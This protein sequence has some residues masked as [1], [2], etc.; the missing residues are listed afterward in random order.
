[1]WG[2]SCHSKGHN[3]EQLKVESNKPF[4]NSEKKYN[5]QEKQYTSN[6]KTFIWHLRLFIW[7]FSSHLRIFQSYG[8]VTMTGEGLLI[9]TYARHLWPLNSEG[10]LACHTYCMWHRASFYNGHLQRPVRLTPIAE[11]LAVELSLPVFTIKVCCSWDWNTQP[12]TCK[13]NALT[14]CDIAASPVVIC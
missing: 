7:G 4:L 12:S 5:F 10:S 8:D 14:H 2:R 6:Y 9:L 13:A 3:R 1:M 11:L